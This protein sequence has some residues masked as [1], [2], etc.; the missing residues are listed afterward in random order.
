M[1]VAILQ[2]VPFEGPAAIGPALEGLG[3]TVAVTRLYAGDS[4]P[5]IETIGGLVIMGGPM[6]V[7][8]TADYPWLEGEL[9]YVRDILRAGEK[10]VLGVCLGAQLMA[11]A[12]GAA[13]TRNPEREI[14]WWP[15]ERADSCPPLWSGVLPSRFDALH[16]HGET[17][18][19]P[20]GAVR[21]AGSAACANQAF[22]WGRRALGLQFHLETTRE[23]LRELVANGAGDLAGGGAFVQDALAL[24]SAPEAA[25]AGVNALLAPVLRGLFAH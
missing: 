18:A 25:F 16:W 3:A 2:H 19:I 22:A 7:H 23:S 17:F 15:V 10:P 8:D 21:L 9:S 4:L 1:N 12:L 20:E 13:V 6:S 14:G 11:A 5:A 24:T